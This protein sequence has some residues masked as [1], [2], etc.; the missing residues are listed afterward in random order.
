MG[1]AEKARVPG[2]RPG[3]VR[4]P[5]SHDLTPRPDVTSA[6]SSTTQDG[7]ATCPQWVLL[8]TLHHRDQRLSIN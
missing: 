5:S 6:E 3:A 7:P 8:S 1:G 4:T 2:A